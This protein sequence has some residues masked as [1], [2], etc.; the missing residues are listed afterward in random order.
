MPTPKNPLILIVDDDRT[1]QM[2]L[3]VAMEQEGFSVV[4]A[5]SGEQCIQDYQR[6][7]PDMVLID[8]M[9]P[10]IDGFECCRQ[11]RQRPGAKQVPIL[12][13]TVLDKP[14]FVERAFQAGAS[15]YI[16]K[17]IS[18]AVLSHRVR[19]LLE[20]YQ[21]A[22]QAEIIKDSL[23]RYQAW[24]ETQRQLWSM[25]SHPDTNAQILTALQ[26]LNQ[27]VTASR[28]LLYQP[29]SQK[30]LEATTQT[31]DI[32]TGKLSEV[33]TDW[34]SALQVQ[35]P[36]PF[37]VNN[38]LCE[39]LQKPFK[40]LCDSLSAAELYPYPVCLKGELTAILLLCFS[41]PSPD[42]IELEIESIQDTAYYIA[43]ALSATG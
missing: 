34:I 7:Q 28:T 2:M 1:L 42:F 14:E 6:L 43:Q 35:F 25:Q 22:R 39:A 5:G 32:L 27:F 4:Q 40:P 20:R 3:K 11:I 26:N 9:M 30:W 31:T 16:T 41:Q 19:A 38:S 21:H 23:S 10:G 8:A 24:K 37:I 13:I 29:L 12:M 36:E 18:W 17:P 15:D 33:S